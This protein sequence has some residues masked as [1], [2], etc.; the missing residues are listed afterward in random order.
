MTEL[1]IPRLECRPSKWK[2]VALLLLTCIM[3]SASYL[4]TTLPGTQSKV[5]GWLGVAFFGLGFIAFPKLLLSGSSPRVVIDAAGI[6]DKRLGVGTI[7][8]ADITQVSIVQVQ[9]TKL[10]CIEVRDVDK[11]LSRRASLGATVAHTN[12]AFGSAPLTIGFVGLTPGADAVCAY[13][14]RYQ[15]HRSRQK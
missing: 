5:V 13:I 8:W 6:Y 2:V 10:L 9:A 12:P 1:T 15:P 11:Y 7:E 14:E 3:V 4:C